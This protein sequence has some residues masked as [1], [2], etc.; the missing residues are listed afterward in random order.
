MSD[1]TA[2]IDVTATMLPRTVI[3]ERSFA[4]QMAAMAMPAASRNL[5][6][7][8]SLG[9]LW[10]RCRRVRLRIDLYLIAVG[11]AAYRV[12]RACDHLIAVLDSRQHLEEPIAGDAELDRHELRAVV[13]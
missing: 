5:F 13:A 9:A 4:A 8:A 7:R 12:I 2:I 10:R 6:T 11:D 3:S 1:T